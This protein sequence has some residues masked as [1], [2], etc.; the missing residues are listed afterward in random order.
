VRRHAQAGSCRRSLGLTRE[1]AEQAC[2]PAPFKPMI[3]IPLPALDLEGH[4]SKHERAAVT[5]A[6]AVCVE[7][8]G[9]TVWRSESSLS[10]CAH[11]F[12]ADTCS[13]FMRSTRLKMDL[14]VRARF[15]VWP[16]HHPASTLKRLIS[17]SA[18]RQ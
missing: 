15:S 9:P 4:V 11:V 8:D 3:T 1:D 12:G 14:A 7:H 6:Q 13:A 17:D 16:P 2:L 5:L 18:L 10:R